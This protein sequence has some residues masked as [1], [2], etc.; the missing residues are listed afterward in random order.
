M[1]L[2]AGHHSG[3]PPPT[4]SLP[5]RPT[6]C[7]INLAMPAKKIRLE[8]C[9]VLYGVGIGARVGQPHGY[10][11]NDF[12]TF[13]APGNTLPNA[14]TIIFLVAAKFAMLLAFA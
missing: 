5:R 14:T 8:G 10:F 4:G 7:V 11:A 9:G 12:V 1:V 2:P 6:S 13:I 3:R